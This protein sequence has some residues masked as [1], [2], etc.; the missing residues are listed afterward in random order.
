MGMPQKISVHEAHMKVEGKT[1]LL[2][3]A[4]EDE[5]KCRG[6]MLDGAIPHS[7]LKVREPLLPKDEEIIFYCA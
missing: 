6:M 3:C 1:A 4:Y 2:V 7:V 5:E